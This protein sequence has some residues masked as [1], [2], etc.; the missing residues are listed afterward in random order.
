MM[1][2]LDLYELYVS[3]SL[4]IFPVY[5]TQ[6]GMF[7]AYAIGRCILLIVDGPCPEAET[8][9]PIFS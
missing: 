6:S 5:P 9:E 1:L 4:S 7:I 3:V 2:F 8:M